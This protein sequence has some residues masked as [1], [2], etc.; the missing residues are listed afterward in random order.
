[1]KR[2]MAIIVLT[3]VLNFGHVGFAQESKTVLGDLGLEFSGD[4][5]FN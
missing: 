5:A 3:V 4:L 2:I 1:M